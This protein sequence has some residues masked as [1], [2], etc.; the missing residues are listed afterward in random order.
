MPSLPL[1][2]GAVPTPDVQRM[3]CL[4]KADLFTDMELV[5]MRVDDVDVVLEGD[6]AMLFEVLLEPRGITQVATFPHAKFLSRFLLPTSTSQVVFDDL[7]P[8]VYLL[9]G[10][11]A[12]VVLCVSL[13][14]FPCFLRIMHCFMTFATQP[15]T[16]NGT[17]WCSSTPFVEPQFTHE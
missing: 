1:H 12:M 16:A 5:S 17:M 8:V 3:V 15:P 14:L 9:D 7:L 6:D 4:K 10:S 13:A 11:R 2:L